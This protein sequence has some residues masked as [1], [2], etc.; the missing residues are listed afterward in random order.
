VVNRKT[1]F[2][3]DRTGRRTWIVKY[4]RDR[5]GTQ[6]VKEFINALPHE[7][8]ELIDRKIDR[9]NAFGPMIPVPHSKQVRGKLRRLKCDF[10][11]L[12]YRVLYTEA[13]HGFIIL[14]HI[15]VKKTPRIPGHEIDL[16]LSRW[17]DFKRRMDALNRVPP[18]AIGRDAP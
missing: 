11:G 7:H 2:V 14:L 10:A 1:G 5:Q 17:D 12:A 3:G 6:P 4:Y 18:R 13:E 9:L 8:Q 15:F 16:A